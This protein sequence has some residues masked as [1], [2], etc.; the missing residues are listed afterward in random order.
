VTE[1]FECLECRA[2]TVVKGEPPKCATC[3]IGWGFVRSNIRAAAE[4]IA[5][6]APQNDRRAFR[7]LSKERRRIKR[8]ERR[9]YQ[10][11]G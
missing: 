11:I 6:V 4:K 3:K 10:I 8:A 7:A 1:Y 2:V 9:G 5:G